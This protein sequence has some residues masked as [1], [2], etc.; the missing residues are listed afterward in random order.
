MRLGQ[1]ARKLAVRP[2]DIVELLATNHIHV[3]GDT[4]TRLNDEALQLAVQHF[5][6]E[7][8]EELLHTPEEEVTEAEPEATAEVSIPAIIAE[9]EIPVA[10]AAQEAATESV[11]PEAAAIDEK[12]E[13]IKATKVELA[14]LKVLGKIELPQPKKKEIKTEEQ[15]SEENAVPASDSPRK[16]PRQGKKPF[17]QDRPDNRPRKNPVAIQREREQREA[18]LKR[19]EEIKREKERKTLYYQQRVKASVP[20]K[21]A[22]LVNEPVVDISAHDMSKT[23]KTWLG[24]FWKWFRS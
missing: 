20:T 11:L 16:Q 3:E 2:A 23:P 15:P 1:L 24:K 13:L 7:R 6:P 8:K 12:P 14:G 9:E 17:K 22:R 19:Q 5:A 4:N 21:P 10:P 18:E